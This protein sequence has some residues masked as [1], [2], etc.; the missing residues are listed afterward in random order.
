MSMSLQTD[1]HALLKANFG[2]E[3]F[4][5][6][7]EAVI[8]RVLAEGDAL[9]LMPTGG[10]K[11]LCY[12]LPALALDGVTL[13]ISPLIALMK[14]QVDGLNANGIAARFIN[15][16]LPVRDVEGVQ[17]EVRRGQVKI[18]YIAPERLAVEGFR[19]FLRGLKVS[20]I[21]IDEAHCISEWGH[22]FRPDYRNLRQLREQFPNVPVLALTATATERV[23]RDIVE[24]LDLKGAEVFVSSFNRANLSYAVRAKDNVER[25]LHVLLERWRGNA[26]IIYCFSRQE[27]EDVAAALTARGWRAS[28]YHAGLA[29]EARRKAQEDFTR[30]RVPI[31]VATIAFGM[32]V[33]KPDV[34]LVVHTSLPKSVES[35]YQE[36]GRA[37]RDGLPSECVLLYSYGDKVRQ[38]FFVKRMDD[39]GERRNAQ[40]KLDQTVRFAQ[41]HTCRRRYLLEYFGERWDLENCGA[42]DVCLASELRGEFDATEIAQKVLSAVVRTGER[43]G[44]TYVIRVLLGSKDQRILAAGHDELSVY[45]IVGDYDRS[46][47]REV[48]GLLQARGLL[49]L[50]DGEYPT[51][52]LTAMGRAFLRSRERMSLP[53]LQAEEKA[54]V[55]LR[56]ST[57]TPLEYDDGLFQ[58]L[59]V[60]RRRLADA[61]DV[62]AFVVFGD[63]ALRHM[64][65]SRPTTLEAF[66][67]IPGVGKAKLEAYGA[68]FVDAICGYADAHGLAAAEGPLEG[69]A[70]RSNGHRASTYD[71]TRELLARGR[72]VEAIARE[73]GISA[74]TVLGHIEHLAHRGEP[75]EVGHLQPAPERMG[76][77][78]EAIAVCGSA[79]LRPLWEY[80]GS[81]YSYD[82]IRIVRVCLRQQGRVVGE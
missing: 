28:P 24:Q 65:A 51:L 46:Q 1:I 43:Y 70:R 35:Y 6:Q 4:R 7:Q 17:G 79:F 80:L 48:L 39:E 19:R 40:T 15:S 59:R 32:G 67:R 34:R 75:L 36:T 14:D 30:D 76:R 8:R 42:C 71:S 77:I 57:G 26:A 18:L 54:P 22:E 33:D 66:G 12:Q 68:A 16:T 63:V 78:E 62:P 21:A 41:L 55:A 29:P 82:E 69:T 20:L 13:V 52:R 60:L 73:R 27:T 3:S 23:R 58:E 2:F 44:E 56:A 9:L 25:Q 31:I 81:G 61:Q 47:L 11:S 53:R 10:G 45:G 5:G 49:A 37:G 38:E 74:K 50:N 64:A 72:S